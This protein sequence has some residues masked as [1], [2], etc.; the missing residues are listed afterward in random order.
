M[1]LDTDAVGAEVV[2]RAIDRMKRTTPFV[3][4]TST[5]LW[6]Q[7]IDQ[8]ETGEALSGSPLEKD[9]TEVI[10][11][12][13]KTLPDAMVYGLWLRTE[14]AIEFCTEFETAY[15]EDEVPSA[16]LPHIPF[17]EVADM[18]NEM[19]LWRI[20]ALAEDERR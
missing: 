6:D 7:L 17:N 4:G 18:V 2:R 9:I 16:E 5:N 13:V 20:D 15:L 11:S 14:E 1:I 8:Q 3:P 19:I 10:W 12:E